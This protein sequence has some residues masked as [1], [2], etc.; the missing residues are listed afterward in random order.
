MVDQIRVRSSI[1]KYLIQKFRNLR[2][3]REDVKNAKLNPNPTDPLSRMEI[4][5]DVF[6][7]EDEESIKL[8]NK[9]IREN[10]EIDRPQ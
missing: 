2:R 6:D 5:Y 9:R 3:L 7:S 8:Y 10:L 4:N 1:H